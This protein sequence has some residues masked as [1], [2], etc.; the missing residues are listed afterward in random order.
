MIFRCS[1]HKRVNSITL[2]IF[3]VCNESNELSLVMNGLIG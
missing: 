1:G 2:I 3:L